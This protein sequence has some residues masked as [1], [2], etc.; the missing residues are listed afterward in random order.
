[1]TPPPVL[2]DRNFSGSPS[3]ATSQSRTCVSSSVQAGLVDQ[4]MPCTARPE[5]RK[6]PRSSRPEGLV[7]EKKEKKG[8]RQKKR[9]GREGGLEK[10]GERRGERASVRG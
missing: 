1:M 3:M 7:G 9:E 6:S 8:R 10:G 5:G 4:S 2:V